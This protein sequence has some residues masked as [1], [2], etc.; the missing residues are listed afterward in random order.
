MKTKI[1][2]ISICML[3]IS[4]SFVSVVNAQENKIKIKAADRV[5]EYCEKQ[6]IP[7]YEE[8]VFQKM[9]RSEVESLY[10]SIYAD[11]METS[12]GYSSTQIEIIL[13]LVT[14]IAAFFATMFGYNPASYVLCLVT[15]SI[16]CFV[17]IIIS[18]IMWAVAETTI[19][20]IAG[21]F[22]LFDSKT[23]D[24]LIY[25][26]GIV[27]TV[28]FFVLLTPVLMLLYLL[29]MPVVSIVNIGIFYGIMLHT[30]DDFFN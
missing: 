22:A 5:V 21:L 25:N 9:N 2:V 23:I 7:R 6:M 24:D 29:A 10:D 13:W 3:L 30:V 17:P 26:Y 28:L 16:V 19:L 8:T 15:V 4:V 12:G 20:G 11:F 27:G 14:L 1:V 18:S